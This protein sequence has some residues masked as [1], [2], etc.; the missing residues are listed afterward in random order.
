[1]NHSDISLKKSAR[2]QSQLTLFYDGKC[3]LCTREMDHLKSKNK[4]TLI[5]IDITEPDALKNYPQI[6]YE[7]AMNVLHGLNENNQILLGLDANCRAWDLVGYGRRVNWLRW[8]IIRELSDRAYLVFA[9]HR[10]RMSGRSMKQERCSTC[11]MKNEK[12]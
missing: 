2:R 1:M 10:H 6:R 3:P 7:K 9:K 12:S 11:T 5:F 8:P 4:G